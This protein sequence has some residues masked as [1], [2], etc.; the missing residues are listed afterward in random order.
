[1][2]STLSVKI[3]SIN[4]NLQGYFQIVGE[5]NLR[6]VVSLIVFTAAIALAS[7]PAVSAETLQVTIDTSSLLGT[8][9]TVTFGFSSPLVTGPGSF[10]ATGTATLSNFLT[11]GTLVGASG[12]GHVSGGLPGA[13]N[14]SDL[15]DGET[16][17]YS[18]GES[19][20][21]Q[22]VFDLTLASGS[23]CPTAITNCSRPVFT[24]DLNGA[25]LGTASL[26]LNGVGLTGNRGI[27]FRLLTAAPVPEPST[28]GMMLLGFGAIGH[29]MRR[30]RRLATA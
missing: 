21:T 5:S 12:H 14:L 22:N 27:S 4:F 15:G 8:F 11:D 16:N 2:S 30:R 13:V 18:I 26:D 9:G 23:F 20:G 24:V 29:S 28:W 25:R 1:L 17:F 10:N 7:T 3:S 6:K 19:F